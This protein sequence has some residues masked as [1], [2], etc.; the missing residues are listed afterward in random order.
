MVDVVVRWVHVIAFVAIRCYA[1]ESFRVVAFSASGRSCCT[2][3]DRVSIHLNTVQFVLTYAV[4]ITWESR[5]ELG[6]SQCKSFQ[7][8]V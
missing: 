7:V 6:N 1:L 2:G 8:D 3:L 5:L 4:G